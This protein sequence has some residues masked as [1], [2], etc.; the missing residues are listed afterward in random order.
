M[1]EAWIIDACRT[2]RGIG[3]AGKGALSSMHPQH[4]GAAV[5]K[6]IAER[7]KI[8]TAEVDDISWGT[9]S[10]RGTHGGDLGRMAALDA[11]YD[12]KSSAVTLDRFCGSGITSVNIAASSVMSGMEDLVLAGGTEMMSTYGQDGNTPSPFMD[13][14]NTRLRSEHPQPHQGVC[15]DAIATLEGID[16]KAVDEL[17]FLSQQNADKAIK[18]GHFDK[19]LIPVYN[20][21]GELVLDK[22]EFPRPQTTLEGLSELKA[23]FESLADYP[24]DEG[25]TTFRKLVLQ[26]YPDLKIN[27]VHHA[28]N[29]SGVVDG[30]AA[31]LIASPNYAKANGMK[32]RA[33][34]KA[35][36]NM[37]DSPTLM[38]NA[39]VP[40]ARKVLEKANL[41]INDIDL[42]EVNEAFSV[43]TEKFIRDLNI[44]REKIN[45]NG[46]AMALGH[47]I[48]ATG[49][50][51]VGTVL[52]ELER[53]D[54]QF[55]LVTMC[56]AG[57]MAPA[58][59]IERV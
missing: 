23:S 22:E 19:S 10:Q 14:G 39:P 33:R 48:G 2:P 45:V 43:V 55:G 21:E 24:L 29:S 57:G 41:T 18:G 25:G 37:G 47:P 8:N 5:L 53:R 56:A 59:I 1:T 36:A 50:I 30:A 16:R 32:P 7:N 6:A 49:S 38:L 58:V 12:V 4:L 42:F 34:I 35:M 46:G 3:K 20:A 9:S 13:N 52:D 28:G 31:L 40:A 54:L 26:K 15:A 44:D 51:L 11:G 27:H 17:A